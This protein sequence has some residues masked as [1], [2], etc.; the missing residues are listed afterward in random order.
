KFDDG[1]PIDMDRVWRMYA[2]AGHKGYMS[3]EY[4]G[5]NHGGVPAEIGVPKLIARVKE[6]CKKYSTV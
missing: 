1:T 2:E 5:D 4:E 3:I 6:L